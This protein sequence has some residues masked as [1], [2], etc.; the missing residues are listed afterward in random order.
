M[1]AQ[2]RVVHEGTGGKP[3]RK[4]YTLFYLLPPA[5]KTPLPPLFE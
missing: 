1:E 4:K 3:K 2:A 5:T